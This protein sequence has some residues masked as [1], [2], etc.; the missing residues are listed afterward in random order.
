M[1]CFNT[2]FSALPAAI[3]LLALS[4]AFI[5][6]QSQTEPTTDQGPS[7]SENASTKIGNEEDLR[8]RAEESAELASRGKWLDLYLFQSPQSRTV[9]K[10]GDFAGQMGV[11]MMLFRGSWELMRTAKLK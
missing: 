6:C 7:V 5:N 2:F 3:L 11:G 10:S 4:V 1:S 8:E 9:C